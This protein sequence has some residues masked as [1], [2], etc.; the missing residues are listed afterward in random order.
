[1]I[2]NTTDLSIV[3]TATNDSLQLS[4]IRTPGSTS[5]SDESCPGCGTYTWTSIGGLFTISTGDG[6]DLITRMTIA[7]GDSIDLGNGSD[8]IELSLG[9][10]RAATSQEAQCYRYCVQTIDNLSASNL[11]GGAGLTDMLSLVHAD[12]ISGEITLS[13]GGAKNFE[14]LIGTNGGDTIRGNADS[15]YLVGHGSRVY[16][17]YYAGGYNRYKYMGISRGDDIIYGEDGDD[18]ILAS[19]NDSNQTPSSGSVYVGN[20]Y[21]DQLTRFAYT[22]GKPLWFVTPTGTRLDAGNYGPNKDSYA[23][24]V[25]NNY[26]WVLED[27]NYNNAVLDYLANMK[28][29]AHNAKLYGGNGEDVLVGAEGEDVL[30]GGPGRDHLVGG[31]GIDTFVIRAGD[32]SATLEGA[33]IVYD[34]VDGTDVIGL[35][36]LTFSDLTISQGTDDYEKDT[37]VSQ[38]GFTMLIIRGVA[39]E[40][41]ASPDFA[42]L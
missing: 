18:F 29:G 35:D 21:S 42:P 38:A 1:M 31:G 12:P 20:I 39:P 3:G 25:A 9:F 28:R 33:D 4:Q 36:G 15:N 8:Y 23:E 16:T 2:G 13:L 5:Y 24:A 6:D 27:E 14:H 10:N 22:L 30:D 32:G 40:N 34:F 11:D 41:V 7:N 26:T 17:N 19:D 37:I